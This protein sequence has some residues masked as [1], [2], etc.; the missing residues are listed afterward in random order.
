MKVQILRDFDST[1]KSFA[2]TFRCL[3]KQFFDKIVFAWWLIKL[4][5][6]HPFRAVVRGFLTHARISTSGLFDAEWYKKKYPDVSHANFDPLNHFIAFGALEGRDPNPLFD[7]NW[8]LTRY[9]D[10][11]SAKRNPLDHFLVAGAQE[12]RDP[13]AWFDTKSYLAQHPEAARAGINPL[14]H[15]LSGGLV[16]HRMLK[17]LKK[18]KTVEVNGTPIKSAINKKIS[19]ADNADPLSIEAAHRLWRLPGSLYFLLEFGATNASRIVSLLSDFQLL[20]QHLTKE[21]PEYDSTEI[22]SWVRK[23]TALVKNQTIND[24]NATPEVS[25]IVP[26]HNQLRHTLCCLASLVSWPTRVTFEV[27]V[28]DDAS[29]D[30]TANAVRALPFPFRLISEPE[31]VGFLYNCNRAALSANGKFIVILNNDTLVL[32]GWLDALVE[33]FERNPTAGLVGSKLLYPNGVLQ[34]AGGLMWTDG[35]GWNIGVGEDPRTPGFNFCRE[36]DYCSGASIALRRELW[37]ELGGFDERYA[38]AYYEDTDLAFRV[39]QAGYTVLYQ[40]LSQL[41]HFEGKSHGT[42]LT[43]GVKQH[44]VINRSTFVETWKAQL[45]DHSGP[46]QVDPYCLRRF[47]QHRLLYIDAFIPTPDQDSGSVDA[48]NFLKMAKELGF[49]VTFLPTDS[50]RHTGRYTRDLQKMGI[51]CLYDGAAASPIPW[52]EQHGPGISLVILSRFPV[53]LRFLTPVR[54]YCPNAKVIFNTVDLNFLREGRQAHLCGGDND[55]LRLLQVQNMEIEIINNSDAVVVVSEAE[56]QLLDELAPSANTIYLPLPREIPNNVADLHATDIVFIGGYKHMPNVD[57]ARYFVQEIWPLVQAQASDA[58]VILAGSNMP[59]EIAILAGN[60]VETIGYVSDLADLF[61]RA[62]VSI[63][64]LQYGAG[65]KGKVV[66][67]LSYGVPVVAT[68]VAAEGMEMTDGKHLLIADSPE[69]FADAVVRLLRDDELWSRLSS[70][71]RRKVN[72]TFGYAKVAEKV[73]K[74]VCELVP[75]MSETDKT[76]VNRAGKGLF[77]VPTPSLMD[78]LASK[79]RRADFQS[80]PFQT[81]ETFQEMLRTHEAENACRHTFE[82]ALIASAPPGE[83]FTFST[84]CWVCGSIRDLY[85]DY[86]CGGILEPQPMPNWRERLVCSGCGLGNRMRATL[87]LLDAVIDSKEEANVYFTEQVTALFQAARTRFPRA[88][89]SEYLRDGTLP[90]QLNADGVRHEDVTN[91]TFNNCTFDALVTLDVLEHVP[92]TLSALREFARVLKPGGTMILTAPFR[93][94]RQE[95]LVR[96]KVDSE[97]HI[98]HIEEPEYHGD[99]MDKGGVLCFYHFGWDLLDHLREVGFSE[100]AVVS[101]WSTRWG[102]LGVGQTQFVAVK[103]M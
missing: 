47:A 102:Y 83:A 91:L 12:G 33:T 41:I 97:G 50:A 54:R 36:V 3:G 48:V 22:D 25:I 55:Q 73:K 42:D 88:I 69:A 82:H 53:S 86:S 68:S 60:G 63:A 38:P 1:D 100:A 46:T 103:E 21:K 8:Y 62:R 19:V 70:E 56:R 57:G 61:T 14:I 39:R 23:V 9:P 84:G 37:Q 93:I 92:D 17:H 34:E 101:F 11:A 94:D 99:P 5:S 81:F 80:I 95:T 28:A 89:G 4:N 44:Q 74:L 15:F 77:T 58:R 7:S 26:V 29:T 40:P 72:A 75:S 65:Q 24:T 43:A 31:N 87:H 2:A 10:V 49:H 98:Q 85:V 30:I 79:L 67:S 35:S 6:E 20:D 32:P 51:E 16:Q 76:S 66:T 90:G 18:L 59:E 78:T 96:A 27:I 52:I 45:A 71:G 13:T 64:P